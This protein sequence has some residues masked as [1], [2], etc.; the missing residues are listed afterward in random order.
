M[1]LSALPKF[2]MD[3]SETGCCPRFDPEPW[4]YQEI[5]FQDRPFVRARTWNFL[6]IPLNIGP[7]FTRTMARIQAAQAELPD[8][9]LILSTDTSAW[10]GEHYFAVA[11]EVPGADN[12]RLSGNFLTMVFEGPYRDAG[13]WVREVQEY[14]ASQGQQMRTL[15][16]FYTTCPKCAKHYGQ[17]YVVAFA[18]I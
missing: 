11:R 4:R 9:Y 1:T 15:Y 16:F 5:T 17:N 13:K 14:V 8:A 10:R 12:V 2:T 6:H 18:E 3:N 7:V